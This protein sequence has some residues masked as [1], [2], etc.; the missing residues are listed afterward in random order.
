MSQDT[1]SNQE[2]FRN[3]IEIKEAQRAHI[4]RSDKWR[5]ETGIKLA[6]A[7][8]RTGDHE[9]A[10]KLLG[11][12]FSRLSLKV[13]E[14]Q[15]RYWLAQGIILILMACGAYFAKLYVQD[16]SRVTSKEEVK[17]QIHAVVEDAVENALS[18]YELP[19]K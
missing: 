18:A 7:N 5:E 16:I 13:S 19:V 1:P 17:G 4:D 10:L 12:E 14:L 11:E 8:E 15:K 6:V 9:K 3:L 2:L